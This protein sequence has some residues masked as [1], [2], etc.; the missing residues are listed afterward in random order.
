MQ[1]CLRWKGRPTVVQLSRNSSDRS[2]SQGPRI[3][4][5]R[6]ENTDSS[7][8]SFSVEYWYIADVL[9]SLVPTNKTDYFVQV[10]CGSISIFGCILL[11]LVQLWKKGLF[12]SK[13]LLNTQMSPLGCYQ[14]P[15]NTSINN[16]TLSLGEKPGSR[17]NFRRPTLSRLHVLP[18]LRIHVFI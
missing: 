3:D 4:W 17:I 7:Q 16:T 9:R 13:K 5:K 1:L 14:F 8:R 18:C 12:Q 6:C 11:A 15:H 10:I 2:C